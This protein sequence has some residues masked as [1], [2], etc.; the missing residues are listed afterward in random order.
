MS[1]TVIFCSGD[2]RVK[3]PEEAQR[4]EAQAEHD[5]Q[6]LDLDL[7]LGLRRGQGDH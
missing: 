6:Q 5:R 4:K 7:E 2:G 1:M 3:G